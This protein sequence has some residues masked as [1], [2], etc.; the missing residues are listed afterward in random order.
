M[1]RSSANEASAN[2]EPDLRNRTLN[3]RTNRMA[4]TA[5]I[6]PQWAWEPYRPS[7]RNPWNY[8]KV[9]HLHRRA[10]FG[11][12][13]QE[14]QQGMAQG[15]EKSI[16]QVLKGG[17]GLE[18]FDRQMT[19]L[20]QNIVAANNEANLRAWWLFRMLYTPFPLQEK[21]T[22]FW[23]DHFATS[24][25]KVA[26]VRYML[27]QNELMRRHALGN[28]AGL[29]QEMSKDP[30]MMVWLDTNLSKKGAP[31]ENY[32]RELMELFSLGIGNY[33]E[34]DVREG[35]RAFTGWEIKD[36]KF[37]FNKGQHDNDAKTFLGRTGNFGGED[38]VRICLE[39][40][41]APVFICRKLY[42]CFISETTP[43]APELLAPLAVQLLRTQYD[44]GSVVSTLLRSNLFYSEHA[45]RTRV[46]S[47]VDFAIGIVRALRDPD[48]RNLQRIGTTALAV[49][50][51]GLGQRIFYPPSVKGWDGGTA[52]INSATLLQRH[53]LALA[54]TS[55]QDDR[56]GRRLDPAALVRKYNK[57]TDEEIVDFFVLLFLQGDLAPAARARLLEYLAS[58]RQQSYPVYWTSN[59]AE[60]HRLRA[61]CHLL[62]TQPEF[63]LD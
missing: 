7:A 21:L 33:T 3:T 43:P 13:W 37:F 42:E 23:H 45:Y 32:S 55:T 28:F 63:Q 30:A 22:L 24:N 51:E 38:I 2:R 41:S 46:K 48:A 61:V 44:I 40:K 10:G 14:L 52:W 62:L 6:D 19:D 5:K 34:Q 53:N 26:N 59:D 11:A 60:D 36:G 54:L 1:A 4:E 57:R 8:A 31:N 27:G 58:A 16:D 49:V 15:P 56:F 20:A 25:A 9:G 18:A 39:Q 50:L 35:A 17:A 47:P 12:N 29:L